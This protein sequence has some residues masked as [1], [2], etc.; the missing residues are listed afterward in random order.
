MCNIEHFYEYRQLNWKVIPI[1]PNTKIPIFN[2][3]NTNYSF[4]NVIR[5]VEKYPQCN[6]GILLGEIVDIEGDSD[7]ANNILNKLTEKIP[8]PRYKSY[9]S[10]HHLF[11]NKDKNLTARRFN[12]IE[13]RAYKHQSILPPST[14]TNGVAYEWVDDV[15]ILPVLPNSLISL[16]KQKKKLKNSHTRYKCDICKKLN[17]VHK[18]RLLLEIEAFSKFGC[19][20]QCQICREIDVRKICKYIN[21]R[22]K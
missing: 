9:K 13:F 12:N 5:C 3:W 8:H 1:Y 7:R 10:V 11:L 6:L 2:K 19:V 4:D 22:Q 15:Q 18:K 21:R 20:W 16:Y 17:I 14:H